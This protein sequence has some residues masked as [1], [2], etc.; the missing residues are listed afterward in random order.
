[1]AC[2]TCINNGC[3]TCGTPSCNCHP[4]YQTLVGSTSTVCD[5]TTAPL[6]DCVT[7]EYCTDGCDSFLKAECI[8]FADG[9]TLETKWSTMITLL[10][11]MAECLCDTNNCPTPGTPSGIDN[12]CL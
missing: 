6:S 10:T 4:C 5:G 11:N 12:I 8:V 3:S 2:T 7:N 1:M 9:E